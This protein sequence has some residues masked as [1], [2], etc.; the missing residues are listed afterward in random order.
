MM[1]AG[2]PDAFV[3]L[4]REM[5][6]QEET[7]LC[8]SDRNQVSSELWTVPPDEPAVS[9]L[10]MLFTS[11]GVPTTWNEVKP[12]VAKKKRPVETIICHGPDTVL[13]KTRSSLERQYVCNGHVIHRVTFWRHR[14]TGCPHLIAARV[15]P[16]S[17]LAESAEIEGHRVQLGEEEHQ[18]AASLMSFE[19]AI[20]NRACEPRYDWKSATFGIDTLP[21]A[22][23]VY[24]ELT[25]F[26][27]DSSN[28]ATDFPS[29]VSFAPM[30]RPRSVSPSSSHT[31]LSAFAG[32]ASAFDS[33]AG[34]ARV[35]E[36][37]RGE[38]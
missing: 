30:T 23:S 10:P 12:K 22:S 28:M 34:I 19:H 33:V 1:R 5:D 27:A 18:A 15:I 35:S 21:E 29:G 20:S 6:A 11:A 14:K 32:E 17:E 26:D 2:L 31:D 13:P 3:N 24:R 8:N 16:A 4:R 38:D 36:T 7:R 37:P 25:R 9:E